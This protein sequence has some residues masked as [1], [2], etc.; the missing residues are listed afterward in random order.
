MLTF[1]RKI[2]RSL[3][4]A[5]R[6][7]SYLLYA[8]GEIALVVIGILIALQINNWNEWR[9]ERIRESKALIELKANLTLNVR[10]FDDFIRDEGKL[11]GNMKKLINYLDEKREYHDSLDIYSIGMTWLEQISLSTSTYET[12]INQGIDFISSDSLRLAIVEL[13]EKDYDHFT[14]LLRDVG[15]SMFSDRSNPL[16]RKYGELKN[17]WPERE[18]Y[19]FL[20]NKIGWKQD[21]VHVAI[22]N[23]NRTQMLIRQIEAE[24][25]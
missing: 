10:T 9:K 23:K 2:R 15:M 11:I 18:L 19:Y 4:A 5:G 17:M 16:M 21:L 20:Q 8:I 22:R 25:D 7:R 13:H 3:L 14:N 6:F 1:L 12:M 24:L